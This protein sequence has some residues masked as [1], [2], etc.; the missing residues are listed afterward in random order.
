MDNF[1][2]KSATFW[3]HI[4]ISTN[5]QNILAMSHILEENTSTEKYV[6]LNPYCAPLG[7]CQV[8]IATSWPNSGSIA[9]QGGPWEKIKGHIIEFSKISLKCTIFELESFCYNIIWVPKLSLQQLFCLG[10]LKLR[11][12]LS[13]RLKG[14]KM[15]ENGTQF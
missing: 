7:V 12:P 3:N 13:Y 2:C 5:F 6:M 4:Y 15:G 11:Y 9:F 10:S 8:T 1:F 14:S